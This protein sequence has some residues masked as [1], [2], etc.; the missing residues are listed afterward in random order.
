[1]DRREHLK[2]LITGS[3]GAGFL[4]PPS[5]SEEDL[6]TSKKI[7][8]DTLYGRTEAERQRDEQLH[9][10]TFF[11]EHEQKTVEV[12]CDIIIP[13][14]EDSG[15]ATDVGVPEF[16]E[17]MMKDAPYMQVPT[18]GGLMWLDNQSKKR[19]NKVFIESS[20][21][22][23]HKLIDEIAYPEEAE[24]EMEYG[25]RFFNHMRNL[26]ATGFFTTKEG[27]QYLDYRGNH[28]NLWDGVPR[29]TLE[30]HGLSYDQKTLNETLKA[31]EYRKVAEWDDEGNLI[32][33]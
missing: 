8:Q 25:V 6:E 1:M 20:S 19:F 23:Q 28:S 21:S 31:E 12:L 33:D 15:S 27:I 10:E 26:T 9:S 11:T 2:L 3:I 18:R 22:D 7:I 4:I 29:K 13:A 14:D 24:P 16:I 5:F 17:F 32:R 30:K